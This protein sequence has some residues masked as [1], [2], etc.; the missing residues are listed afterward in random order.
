[1]PSP[2]DS[3]RGDPDRPGAGPDRPTQADRAA[4]RR[5]PHPNRAAGQRTPRRPA[6]V[7]GHPHYYRTLDTDPT[8]A[9]VGWVGPLPV[10]IAVHLSGDDARYH[11]AFSFTAAGDTVEAALHAWLRRAA[12]QAWFT[13][14]HPGDSSPGWL[15]AG[16]ANTGGGHCRHCSASCAASAAP[17]SHRDQ[18][19]V[20]WPAGRCPR[21]AETRRI[22]AAIDTADVVPPDGSR[23]SAEQPHR[24][25]TR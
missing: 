20:L 19:G 22:V 12:G 1:M 10:I 18:S 21:C 15:P 11:A 23:H 3:R 9:H 6:S 2:D 24:K 17:A 5:R 8:V 25:V 13:P 16:A 4:R 14:L 7:T